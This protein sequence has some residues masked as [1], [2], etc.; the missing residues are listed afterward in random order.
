MPRLTNPALPGVVIDVDEAKA[1]NRRASG[2]VD[3]VDE[4]NQSA[5]KDDWVAY[6]NSQGVDTDGLTKQQLIDVNV[7]DSD[8]PSGDVNTTTSQE[9]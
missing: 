1:R 7:D 3:V 5:P 9:D 4:P 8:V 6:R 2:W